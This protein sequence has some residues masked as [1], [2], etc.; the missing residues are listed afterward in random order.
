MTAPMTTGEMLQRLH[1]PFQPDEIKWKAQVVR[2]NRALTVAYVDARCVMDRL[3]DVCGVDGWQDRYTV[4][5]NN[6][7]MCSLSIKADGVW[8]ERADCGSQSD[9]PDE[10]DRL[11]SA[12]SDALKRAAVKFGIGRYLYRLPHQWVDYDP[13]TRQLKATPGLPAWAK[14]AAARKAKGD[15]GDGKAEFITGAHWQKIV[16]ALKAHGLG[17]ESQ[18]ALMKHFGAAR[19]GEI[20]GTDFDEA[21]KLAEHPTTEIRAAGLKPKAAAEPE[22]VGAS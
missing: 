17:K 18:E 4:L 7:V 2:G 12:F 5:P 13:Q 10:G 8:I 11:K 22:K 19:P 20:A 21:L 1:D 6:S 16:A 9:Q 15:A 14:P 3:D